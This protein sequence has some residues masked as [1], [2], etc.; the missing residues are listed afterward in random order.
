ML[1]KKF[2]ERL[3]ILISLVSL[4][5]FVNLKDLRLDYRFE[6]FFPENDPD[7]VYY[8]DFVNEFE[9]DNDFF[10]VGIKNNNGIFKQEFLQKLE[11]LTD[12]LRKI[13][14][15]NSI[16][17]PTSLKFPVAGPFGVITVPY[18]HTD[19]PEFYK[20][21][22]ARIYESENLVG[23]LFS[24]DGKIVSI[25]LKHEEELV[26]SQID[27]LV[28][29]VEN[30]VASF[31]FDET[32]IVGKIR[33]QHYFTEQM[34]FELLLFVGISIILV[35]LF[36]YF[37]F[38]AFWG[39][40][41]PF[42]VI[43]FSVLWLLSL[44]SFINKP[45]NLL[46]TLLPT[47]LFVVGISNVVHILER[48]IYE[49]RNKAEKLKAIKIA[50]KEVG[51]ATFLTSFTTAVGFFT[52]N[53]SNILPVKEFGTYTAIGVLISFVLAFTLLPSV[54]VIAKKPEITKKGSEV[55]FW[56]NKLAGLFAWLLPN[57]RN[58]L[59]GF[60]GLIV[61]SGIGISLLK[62]DN[63]FIEDWVVKDEIRDDY[64]FFEKQFSGF[65]PFDIAIWVKD[66]STSFNDYEVLK[67]LEI[68]DVEIKK[69]YKTKFVVSPLN[70][71]KIANQSIHGGKSEYYKIPDTEK[72]YK[73]L[74]S[75]FRN[76]KSPTIKSFVNQSAKKARF[77]AK[78]ID[79]GGA[80][81]NLLN[82]DIENSLQQK[83]NPKLIGFQL[84]GMPYLVDKNN[85]NLS[86]NLIIGLLIAFLIVAVLMGLLFKSFSMIIVALIPNILPLGLIAAFMG[87]FGI[88]LKI[89]TSI[90]FT[91]AF[92]IAVDDTIHFMS[93]YR[94]ELNK[95][96]DK[97]YALK[98]TFLQT[99]KAIVVTSII[100]S[101]GFFILILS[102]VTSSFYIGLLISLTL[103]FALICNLVLLP[104]LILYLYNPERK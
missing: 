6:N 53:T 80:K 7:L 91:I 48:F 21:D 40:W 9:T 90:I 41:V 45:I 89:A 64:R 52:L 65:R 25:Q 23:S 27:Q 29:N 16:K 4:V 62:V 17:S 70:F 11:A 86:T 3:I 47:I 102:Q 19:K 60:L 34:I 81:M 1:N 67:E 63:F 2:A 77:S 59:A 12:T 66:S 22:S 97:L 54:L 68:I 69:T 35:S 104:V 71:V 75:K 36:L 38:R 56:T 13:E 57:R 50:F 78:I 37:S 20:T 87:Y 55:H 95:N 8:Y 33:G 103:L 93:K 51:L 28:L 84:T 92:G 101:S 94:I 96:K 85:K 82:Q 39:V 15:I 18:I 43:G 26:K 58:V 83:L 14:F 32:H 46:T 10:I 99:G 73:S 44:L 31:D 88:D 98:R 30:T 72:E 5:F 100:L 24:E 74:I 42:L 79:Y 61:I 76:F 49:L